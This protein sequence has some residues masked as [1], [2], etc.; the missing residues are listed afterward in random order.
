MGCDYYATKEGEFEMV[1]RVEYDNYENIYEERVAIKGLQPFA[2]IYF[3]E[4]KGICRGE[5]RE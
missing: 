4:T 5:P 3:D 2:K 1:I